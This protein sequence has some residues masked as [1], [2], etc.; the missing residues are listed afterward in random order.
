MGL[1]I[2]Q[3]QSP[4][5]TGN[6]PHQTFTHPQPGLVNGGL[7][8]ALGGEQFQYLA[9]AHHIARANFGHHIGRNQTNGLIQPLLSAS[10]PSHNIAQTGQKPPR[11]RG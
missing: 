6:I 8:Q 3:R 10:P 1:G 2:G 4:R 5:L 9:R 11:N 7:F